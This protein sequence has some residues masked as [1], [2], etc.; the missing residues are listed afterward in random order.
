MLHSSLSPSPE[1]VLPFS[2]AAQA[3]TPHYCA[4]EQS[5]PGATLVPSIAEAAGLNR[6]VYLV[7]RSKRRYVFSA[8]TKGQTSLYNGAIFAIAENHKNDNLWTGTYGDL[9]RLLNRRPGLGNKRIFVH[10]LAED[11][12]AKTDIIAD[13]SWNDKAWKDRQE[14][15]PARTLAAIAS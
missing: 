13:L 4:R 9:I 15:R 14:H 3:V 2:L 7:G 8:I 11:D 10:L 1:T 6:F 5:G 12:A